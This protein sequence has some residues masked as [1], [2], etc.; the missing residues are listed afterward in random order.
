[1]IH[2]KKNTCE[3]KNST[4]LYC[5]V[6]LA[7]LWLDTCCARVGYKQPICRSGQISCPDLFSTLALPSVTQVFLIS[8][9]FQFQHIY[10]CFDGQLNATQ[11]QCQI[12]ENQLPCWLL[13]SVNIPFVPLSLWLLRMLG[14]RRDQNMAEIVLNGASGRDVCHPRF[15]W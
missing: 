10:L 9:Y 11:W 15:H 8:N 13:V 3:L 14:M 2:K 5:L 6:T 12:C 4:D 1:M 7:G